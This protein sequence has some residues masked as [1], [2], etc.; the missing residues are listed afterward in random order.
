MSL[1]PRAVVKQCRLP[2]RGTV[3]KGYLGRSDADS[4]AQG[5]SFLILYAKEEKAFECRDRFVSAC[6]MWCGVVW[7]VRACVCVLRAMLGHCVRASCHRCGWCHESVVQALY[8]LCLRWSG[9]AAWCGVGAGRRYPGDALW[10][11]VRH[12]RAK[13]VS[14]VLAT[15]LL[16]GRRAPPA[17][18]ARV[19][20]TPCHAARVG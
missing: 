1:T 5:D 19:C 13:A 6:V 17:R 7:C 8:Q 18:A 20:A 12:A 10:R 14:F 2:I 3:T 16:G 11:G 15:G 9:A 4:L